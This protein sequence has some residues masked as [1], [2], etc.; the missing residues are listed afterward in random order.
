LLYWD[1]TVMSV[2]P[3]LTRNNRPVSAFCGL[4]LS[5]AG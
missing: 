1:G 2:V 4:P 5:P 3:E